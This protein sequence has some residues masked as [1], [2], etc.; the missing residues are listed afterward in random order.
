MPYGQPVLAD[1]KQKSTASFVLRWVVEHPGGLGGPEPTTVHYRAVPNLRN[2]KITVVA[3]ETGRNRAQ[4]RG[5][6]V[7]AAGR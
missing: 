6:G 2:L 7:C 5:T 1:L 3:S 4:Q